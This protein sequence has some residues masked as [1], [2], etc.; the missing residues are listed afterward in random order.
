MP[1]YNEVVEMQHQR[2]CQMLSKLTPEELQFITPL[3]SRLGNLSEAEKETLN[4]IAVRHNLKSSKMAEGS[5][6]SEEVLA[7]LATVEAVV[8]KV[9]AAQSQYVEAAHALNSAETS[10][11]LARLYMDNLLKKVVGK[12]AYDNGELQE[13]YYSGNGQYGIQSYNR[14]SDNVLEV[15]L[16]V[17]GEDDNFESTGPSVRL[18]LA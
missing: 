6:S 7:A 15:T 3:D 11:R 14:L 1:Y 10:L 13:Y 18:T 16:W 2:L 17:C 5:V 12:L 9:A 8:A 4:T